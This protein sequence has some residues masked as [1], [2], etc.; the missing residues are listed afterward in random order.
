M[1]LSQYQ[2]N[3]CFGHLEAAYHIFAYLK[4]HLDMGKLVFNSHSPKIED[5]FFYANADWKDFYGDITE[6]LPPNM[7][8]PWGHSVIISAF[9]DAN[10]A[11][12]HYAAFAHWHIYL[13]SECTCHLVLKESKHSGSGYVRKRICG[14]T[15][16][17]RNDRGLAL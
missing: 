14:T 15:D 3:P 7:P 6:E 8:E 10:H 4:K 17:Q 16:L 9:I 11:S 5:S 13:C 2:A 12:R 1:Q